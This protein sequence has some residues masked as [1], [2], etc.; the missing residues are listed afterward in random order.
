MMNAQTG[1]NVN[2][3]GLWWQPC[4]ADIGPMPGFGGGPCSLS[5]RAIFFYSQALISRTLKTIQGTMDSLP[6]PNLHRCGRARPRAGPI[7]RQPADRDS[8]VS[9]AEDRQADPGRG[10]GR[11][12]ARPSFAKSIAAWQ[13][14]PLIRMQCYEGLDESRHCM[15]GN[16]PS[17]CSTRQILKDKIGE[18]LGGNQET[19][20]EC[21]SP[22]CTI[23]ATCS[24]PR[25]S[26]SPAR[27]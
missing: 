2:P 3:R 26:S 1:R 23:S 11:R 16:T 12:P 10:P 4:D 14:I 18:V 21:P 19:L 27:C 17:S 15:S 25:N 22:S 9:R 20:D 8:T 7:H 24:S 6:D 5:R 13:N